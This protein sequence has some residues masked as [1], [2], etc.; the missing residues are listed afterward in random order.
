MDTSGNAFTGEVIINVT[1]SGGGP[2]HVHLHGDGEG[3][4]VLRPAHQGDLRHA[5]VALLGHKVQSATTSEPLT[6]D[7]LYQKL[8]EISI[9]K[10]QV[11]DANK[12]ELEPGSPLHYITNVKVPTEQGTL[13]Y[14]YDS[15]SNTGAG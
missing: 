11:L 14:N 1:P 12:N 2:R 9:K 10:T 4:A 15:E 7:T 3:R 13:Y 6:F 8:S 5:V